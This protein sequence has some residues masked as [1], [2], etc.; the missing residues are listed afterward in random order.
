MLMESVH[1]TIHQTKSILMNLDSDHHSTL[2]NHNQ[3]LLRHQLEALDGA[4]CQLQAFFSLVLNNFSID[5]KRMSGEIIERTMPSAVHWRLSQRTGF[6]SSPSEYASLAA[7]TVI[8]QVLEA[9]APLSEDAR[10]E[11]L[12]V[13]MTAF[14][15]AWMEHILRQKIKFSILLVN[16][17]LMVCSINFGSQNC[18]D[19]IGVQA[20]QFPAC[21]CSYC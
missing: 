15:E 19:R 11:A 6:P 7:Q 21:F 1:K 17:G 13:T 16:Q 3:H 14:M 4:A 20:I 8:G 5:C 10:V 2:Q 9:V 18:E 12:S